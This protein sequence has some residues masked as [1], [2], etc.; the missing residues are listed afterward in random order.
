MYRIGHIV[1]FLLWAL[2]AQGQA[3]LCT[4]PANSGVGGFDI[5]GG[6]NAG[7]SPLRVEVINTSG[8]TDI[9]YNFDYKGQDL[10]TL[11]QTTTNTID[12]LFATTSV[13]NYTILQYGKDASGKAIYACKTVSVRPNIKPIVSYSSCNNTIIS[14]TIPDTSVNNFDYYEI[15]WGDGA[16][17]PERVNSNQLTY[18]KS[19]NLLLPKTIEVQGFYNSS[20]VNC[21]N[22]VNYNLPFLTPSSFPLGFD[23]PYHPNI[24][25]LRLLGQN[26]VEL[27]FR[28]AYSD[29]GY[30]L[31]RKEQAGSYTKVN[32]GIKPGKHIF[33][34]PD[35]TKSYCYYL[36]RNIPC[37]IEV[38]AEL[39]TIPL[40]SISFQGYNNV[41]NWGGYPTEISISDNR[42]YG[43]Y[44]DRKLVIEKE[45]KKTKQKDLIPRIE[46]EITFTDN[47][48][49]CN[50]VYCYEV[51]MNTSGQLY[52]H[53]FQGIS[54]SNKVCSNRK[55]ITPPPLNDLSVS[56]TSLQK[57]DLKF[58]DNVFWD[59]NKE[60]Y[61][62]YQ[63]SLLVDS[64][65]L[66][67]ALLID[68]DNT[69]TKPDCFKI[70]YKD[71]C[72]SLSKFS[73]E[74]CNLVLN[75]GNND[76]LEWTSFTPFG[77]DPIVNYNIYEI[78]E[79]NGNESL[80]SSISSSVFEFQPDLSNFDVVAKFRVEAKNKN[81]IGSLSNFI[82]IPI[83]T[84]LYLPDV[85]TPND[86]GIND[87]LEIKGK[88]NRID[89]FNFEIINRWGETIYFSNDISKKWD[90]EIGNSSASIGIYF[91][92][93]NIKLKDGERLIKNG[94]FELIR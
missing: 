89:E 69:S 34:I 56:V 23:N 83:K 36:Q 92:K 13:N 27:T 81:G 76:Q 51:E 80:I 72:G 53:K 25:T 67:V 9:H 28:G 65:N 75:T 20:S 21:Q 31:W 8:S 94:S 30:E 41:L 35:S 43:R 18:S 11:S 88:L 32:S 64:L 47:I 5:V 54:I 22:K 93:L 77:N 91:Y 78:N 29:T 66:P 82:E 52:Y 49:D 2:T 71:E 85:F 63:N 6:I 60:K 61:Y 33:S 59:F 1:C 74:V 68:Y 42:L 90:G 17:I 40:S 62:V 15:N 19:R 84:T 14:I 3:N 50:V 48:S 46:N 44:L 16:P 79:N 73:P 70:K 39:C 87:V 4:P 24:D 55:E 26:R 45:N 37:G 10:S 38:S 7:C 12:V 86:D 57:I 58:T